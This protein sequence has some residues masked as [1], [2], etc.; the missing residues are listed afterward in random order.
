M[1][2]H[3]WKWCLVTVYKV[4]KISFL[5]RTR[6]QFFNTLYAINT[7]QLLWTTD[8]SLNTTEVWSCLSR[9]TEVHR[10]E[11]FTAS[12]FH[13]W[14]LNTPKVKWSVWLLVHVFL[15]AAVIKT[16]STHLV[17]YQLHLRINFREINWTHLHAHQHVD[18]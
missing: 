9:Q 8:T 13:M 1:C 6:L 2:S 3:W 15:N 11:N 4:G 14:T 12:E 16:I 10:K 5:T 7:T 17:F 18:N